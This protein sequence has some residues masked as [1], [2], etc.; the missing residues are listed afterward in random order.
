[1]PWNTSIGVHS[2]RYF[3]LGKIVDLLLH[4]KRNNDKAKPAERRGRKATGPRFLR[5][6][7][8]RL[9]EGP[10]IAGLPN[11]SEICEALQFAICSNNCQKPIE[12]MM[13]YVPA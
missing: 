4:L 11:R 6:A 10:K 13:G 7:K 2:S 12:N 9:P 1:V 3:P 8:E 5:E